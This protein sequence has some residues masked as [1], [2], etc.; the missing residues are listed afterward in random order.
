MVGKRHV[1]ESSSELDAIHAR[2]IQ[3][4]NR[5]TDDPNIG[6]PG[7]TNSAEAVGSG[8]HWPVRWGQITA[9]AR[10]QLP[11]STEPSDS[12]TT[13]VT[14]SSSQG[15][16]PRQMTYDCRRCSRESAMN[17]KR[18]GPQTPRANDEE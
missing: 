18:T 2:W 13:A 3:T 4:R 11:P 5:R 1:T 15:D 7:T 9:H 14:Y 17:G 10:I 12:N 6:S 16:G 8:F